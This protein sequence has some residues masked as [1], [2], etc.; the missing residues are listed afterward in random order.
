MSVTGSLALQAGA[1]DMVQISPTTASFA[2]VTGAAMLSGATVNANY[3]AGSDASKQY[4]ILTTTGGISGT[5][6]SLVN[7]P[8]VGSRSA[9]AYDNNNAYLE[10]ELEFHR[11]ECRRWPER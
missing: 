4:T 1:I 8:S 6:G 5:F 2:S 11:S 3:A 10:F 9:L 7:T